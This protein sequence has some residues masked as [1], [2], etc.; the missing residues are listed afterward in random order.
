M[1]A[2]KI[3]FVYPKYPDT[4]W[5]FK[6]ALKF[7][8]KKAAFPPLGLLTIA[9]M[10]P[11]EWE[12]KLVDMNVSALKNKD[13]KWADCVFISAMITQKES[14]KEVIRRC[15]KLGAKIVAGG[16]VFTTGYEEFEGVDHFVL[17]EAEATL[18]QFL[19]DFQKGC[20]KQ[21]YASDEHPDIT[22]TPV[23]LWSLINIRHYVSLSIQYSRGCP[24]NCEFCDIIVMNGR[25][26]RTKNTEQL[27][28]ELEAVY[29]TGF[30][31][32]LFIVDDNFIG[33]KAK[34]KQV[35]PEVIQWQ[36]QRKYPFWI[37]T[38]SSLD[39]ADDEKL[40]QMMTEAGFNKVFV[41]LETPNKKSLAECNKFRNENRDMTVMVKNIQNHGLQVLGGYI[42]G[43][44]NDSPDI[45]EEQ[46]SFIQKTGVVVAMVGLLNALPKT[47][48]Y[49]RL[50]TEKR[51]L[52][53]ASGNNTDISINF[54]PKMD[55]EIL[56]KGYQKIIQTIYS[57][58]KYYER[59]IAFFGEYQPLRKRQRVSFNDFG[60]LLGSI[61]HLGVTG[62]WNAKWYYWKLIFVTCLK[63]RRFFSEAIVLSIYGLHFRKIAETIKKVS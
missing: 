45:F 39:L 15:N 16:P 20:A 19:E 32:S 27:L 36:K 11:Q 51:L 4:F 25:I 57:P 30:R 54:I 1:K 3:L 29:Q 14:A 6:H 44:D 34:I 9:A 22:R 8:S 46:I 56:V 31:G 21:L 50:A 13:I 2:L 52:M 38:E 28:Q 53:E 40:M 63:Y 24:Y 23:P 43:F 33:N 60:A 48:L 37:L 18:P 62:K 17:G 61:W 41:G 10:L 42:V 49:H 12:K 35:L 5:S 55:T 26:P 58:K 7:V 59:I 47:K